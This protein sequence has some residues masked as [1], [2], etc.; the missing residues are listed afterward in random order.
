LAKGVLLT[1]TPTE[2]PV[3]SPPTWN[4]I[5]SS[6]KKLILAVRDFH[7]PEWLNGKIF[8]G[9][10]S[11]FGDKGGNHQNPNEIPVLA[12]ANITKARRF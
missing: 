4:Q 7:Q 8:I 5:R 2:L 10:C 6:Q 1:L 12:L 11:Q 9:K 3:A